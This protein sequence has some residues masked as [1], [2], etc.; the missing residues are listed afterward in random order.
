MSVLQ[1]M[2]AETLVL[3]FLFWATGLVKARFLRDPGIFLNLDQHGPKVFEHKD[4]NGPSTSIEDL[5][6]GIYWQTSHFIVFVFD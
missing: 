4:L 5:L 1:V 2:R 6:R 3:V